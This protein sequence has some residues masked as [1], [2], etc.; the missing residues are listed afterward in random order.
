MIIQLQ[1]LMKL[2]ELPL[3]V[4]VHGHVVSPK[5][6]FGMGIYSVRDDRDR[7]RDRNFLV[8]VNESASARRLLSR[9]NA[10]PNETKTNKLE[11]T[12]W[13]TSIEV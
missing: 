3:L 1:E 9:G 7:D 8:S 13:P 2:E 6:I 4:C 11:L 10:N 5:Y 12:K